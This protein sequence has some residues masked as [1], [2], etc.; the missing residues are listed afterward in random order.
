MGKCQ[1]V[2]LE[3]CRDA[4][5]FEKRFSSWIKNK[6]GQGRTISHEVY[7][8]DVRR[9]QLL[10]RLWKSNQIYEDGLVLQAKRTSCIKTDCAR[11]CRQYNVVSCLAEGYWAKKT[12]CGRLAPSISFWGCER[13]LIDIGPNWWTLYTCEH[14]SQNEKRYDRPRESC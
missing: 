2:S 4:S 11:D 14:C 12:Q 1:K 9:R 8:L 5:S 6:K 7:T 13:Y 10:E 3:I